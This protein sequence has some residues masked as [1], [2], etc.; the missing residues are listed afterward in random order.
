MSLSI[1]NSM[2]NKK[3]H[4]TESV[5]CLAEAKF[6]GNVVKGVK[7]LGIKS[8]N[9]RQ[10]PLDVMQKA[11]HKY[12]GAMIALDHPSHDKPRSV[13]DVFGRIKNPR[14]S[15][16]GIVADMEFNPDHQYAKAFRWFV[17]NDPSAVG[18]SHEAVAKTK[19]DHKTGIEIVEDIVEVEAVS[20]VANPATNPK[21]LFESYNKIMENTMSKENEQGVETKPVAEVT[22]VEPGKKVH[23]KEAEAEKE[24]ESFEAYLSDMHGKMKEIL[25]NM[26][27]DDDAK[28]EAISSMFVPKDMDMKAEALSDKDAV[29]YEEE[30]EDDGDKKKHAEGFLRK[31]DKLGVKLLIEELDS[32]RVREAQEKLVAKIH[33]TCKKAGLS[34]KLMTEAFVDILSSVSE[35]KWSKLIEDRKAIAVVHKAPISFSA[36]AVNASQVLT[37]EQLMAQLR[38]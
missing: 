28:C 18:L 10:Y 25:G 21:G 24:Y 33:E 15:E 37:V 6:D 32:Y 4:I 5:A 22:V 26:E 38:G 8:K 31:S 1:T 36:D 9:G 17:D 13:V 7:V 29:K 27:M 34:E 19:M 11:I 20:L 30:P 3:K 35:D 23:H 14:M 16:T 2:R 12:E